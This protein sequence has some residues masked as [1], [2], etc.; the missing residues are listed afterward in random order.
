MKIAEARRYA[1]T[2]PEVTEEPHFHLSSFRVR[3]KIFATVPPDEEHLHIFVDKQER[4]L[5][6]AV[7]PRACEKLKWGKQ[8]AGLRVI[9]ANAKVADVK[10]LLHSAWRR[11][12]PK[13]LAKTLERSRPK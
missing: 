1:L 6:I 3:G 2:L 10:D 8:V 13:S 9:L 12:A 11:K 5:A 4:E 7:N